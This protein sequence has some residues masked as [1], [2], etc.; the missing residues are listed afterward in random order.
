MKVFI[1]IGPHPQ[2]KELV[3][4]PP[5]GVEYEIRGKSGVSDYYS[6]NI[7]KLRRVTNKIIKFTGVPRLNYYKTNADIIFS[8]R[9]IIPLT[10]KPWVAEIEHPYAFVG[11]DYKN[12]GK[13]QKAWV[14]TFLRMRYC[15]TIMPNSTGAYVALK[16]SFDISNIENK[17]ETVYLSIHYK[18]IIKTKH[19]GIRLLTI[20]NEAY[21]RGFNIIKDIYPLLKRK[22][23]VEWTIKSNTT[24]SKSDSNFIKKYGVRVVNELLSQKEMDALY[25]SSDIFLYPSFVDINAIVTYEAMRAGMPVVAMDTY[26]FRDKILPYKNGLLIKDSGLFWNKEFLRTGY[27]E[28]DFFSTYHNK[29]MSSELYD[30]LEYLIVHDK[31]RLKMG[32]NAAAAIKNGFLSIKVRNKKLKDIFER[33]LGR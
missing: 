10:T 30:K 22:Y 8:T 9:G 20:T 33:A 27:C 4:Y 23:G 2:Y 31:E 11:M 14:K 12:W 5:P 3:D 15:K 28:G 17:I 18:K 24:F 25:G 13:I 7:N 6:S 29:K 21:Q 1:H 16:N 32:K 19:R 26:G